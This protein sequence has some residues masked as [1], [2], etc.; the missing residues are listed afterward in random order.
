MALATLCP[1]FVFS[2]PCSAAGDEVTYG[3][4]NVW[5][6]Y[7]YNNANLNSYRGYVNE[8]SAASPNFDQ[9]FGGDD[10]SY[11]THNCS[12]TTSTFSIR[13]RLRKTFANGSYTFLVA[14]DDGYRLSI[15][16]G[17]TWIIDRWVDQ[18]YASTSVSV[19][20]NGTYNLVLEYYENN[21]ANR[22]SFT[23]TT[24][25]SGSENTSL[26]GSSNIWNGYVYDGINFDSYK[27][28]VH[29]G[30][31][32]SPNFDEN[33][34]GN[35]V[36]YATTN[37]NVL[38]ETFS[39]RYR[40]NKNFP[41]GSY[42]FVV[43]A[44]DGY[45]LSLDGGATWVINNWNGHSYTTSTYTATVS[46][47]L[48]VVLD[49]YES[50]QDNRVSFQLQPLLLL[51][52]NLLSFS[53]T[54]KNGGTELKWKITRDSDPEWFDIQRSKDAV[55]FTTVNRLP[56]QSATV[57]SNDLAYQYNDLLPAPG[58]YFYRLKMTDLSGAISYSPVINVQTG[59]S[60]SKQAMLFPTIVDNHVLYLQ[61][62]RALQHSRYTIYDLNGKPVYQKTPGR[63]EAGQVI[64]LFPANVPLA[65]GSYIL[66][67]E[68]GD[69]PVSRHRFM[70]P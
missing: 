37:C 15:D 45:R 43:G 10:V 40:L 60:S 6:G 67:L 50:N 19:P 3:T 23:L 16:G 2:Q 25:C 58:S 30:S 68:D 4:N 22:V 39:V 46:G 63:L 34:G 64:N 1:F 47:W 35:S 36:S 65:K 9:S 61:A 32:S 18:G 8:G 56:G 48:N 52:V 17:T 69:E 57:Y 7:V 13:Y 66:S 21:G 5:I 38:S 42:R 59:N 14:A 54:E 51:P 20:L 62:G 11:F 53:G 29:E 26:Y 33:F 28:M 49:Y 31:H 70:V 12:V 41:G 27:G 55:S 24:D 44:D